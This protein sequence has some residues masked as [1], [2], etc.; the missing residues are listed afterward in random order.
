MRIEDIEIHTGPIDFEYKTLRNLEARCEAPTAFSKA[1]TIEDVNNKLREM[2]ASLGAN[3]VV[4]VHYDSGVTLTSWRSMRG[5]GV[6]VSRLSSDMPC[7]ICAETIKRVA[8]KCRFCGADISLKPSTAKSVIQPDGGMSHLDPASEFDFPA[9][10]SSK[11]SAQMETLRSTDNP[12]T[13]I[14]FSVIVIV[15]LFLLSLLA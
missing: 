9:Y 14:I 5:F 3:A 7:P 11:R 10:N 15:V 1:P 12:Q 8:K 2:A 6:A 13:W 4:D